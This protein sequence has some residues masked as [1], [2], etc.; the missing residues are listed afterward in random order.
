MVKFYACIWGAGY[1]GVGVG[2]GGGGGGSGGDGGSGGGGLGRCLGR[3]VG[4]TSGIPGSWKVWVAPR[5]DRGGR[6][7]IARTDASSRRSDCNP[8]GSRRTIDRRSIRSSIGEGGGAGGSFARSRVN[9]QPRA[10]DARSTRD[11][12]SGYSDWEVGETIVH[13]YIM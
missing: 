13:I 7:T 3:G 1:V 5:A 8:D 2:V 9:D 10:I 11:S 4:G 12:I 6:Q